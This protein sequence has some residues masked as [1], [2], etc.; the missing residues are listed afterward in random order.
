M[1][2]SIKI[3]EAS[4]LRDAKV[5]TE[6]QIEIASVVEESLLVKLVR[7][8]APPSAKLHIG[9]RHLRNANVVERAL[10]QS[11]DCRVNIARKRAK[12]N[13][14]LQAKNE[15]L[16]QRQRQEAP[17]ARLHMPFKLG[18]FFE[19]KNAKNVGQKERRRPHISTTLVQ[20]M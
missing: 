19:H 17:I 1:I 14:R 8:Y 11:K 6:S 9:R 20:W 13:R 10:G 7:S 4:I 16:W 2:L 12:S 3:N 5:V 18:K 15:N